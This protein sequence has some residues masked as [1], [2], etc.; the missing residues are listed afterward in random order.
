MRIDRFEEPESQD[1]ELARSDVHRRLEFKLGQL[2]WAP[3][4]INGPLPTR[5]LWAV[6]WDV[7]MRWADGYER[8]LQNRFLKP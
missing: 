2:Q 6:T 4:G 5:K 3:F 8:S 1:D 7:S